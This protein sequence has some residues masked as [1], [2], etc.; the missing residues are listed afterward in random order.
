VD[1]AFPNTES[2]PHALPLWFDMQFITK[3]EIIK[4]HKNYILSI[5]KNSYAKP[6]ISP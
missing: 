1:K 5:M 6:M 2:T 3:G 4:Y